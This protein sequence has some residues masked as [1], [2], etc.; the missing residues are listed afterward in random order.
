MGMGST[1][2]CAAGITFYIR[3]PPTYLAK[4]SKSYGIGLNA[5][6]RPRHIVVLLRWRDHFDEN[7]TDAPS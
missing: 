1:Q 3:F 4:N 6:K 5:L 2:L 7:I